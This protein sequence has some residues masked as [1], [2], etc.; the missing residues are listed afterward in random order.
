MSALAVGVVLLVA[1]GAMVWLLHRSLID[2]LDGAAQ[3]RAAEIAETLEHDPARVREL[4]RA[5]D[6]RIA[7]AQVVAP[8]GT[9]IWGFDDPHGI[10]ATP[11]AGARRAAGLSASPGYDED[12]RVASRVAETPSGRYQVLVA[13]DTESVERAVAR[14]GALLAVGAPIVVLAAAAATYLLVG[15]S[16]RSVEAIRERVARI[17]A[18]ELSE[19]VPVPAPRDEI[20]RL[21]ET[22]NDMLARVEAGHR[23][24][25]RFV[26]DA[27]HELRSPL[28]TVTAALELA[29]HRPEIV[30]AEL[31]DGTLL[32]EAERMRR[33]IDDLLTLAAAD[34]QG[35]ELRTGDVDLD[36]IAQSAAAAARLRGERTVETDIRPTRI[37]GDPER[38]ARALRNIVDNA[39]AHARSR[40]VIAVAENSEPGASA[41]RI[42]VD[43]DGPGIPAA[44]RMRVFDRFV[45]LEADRSR[46]TGGSGLGLAIVAE[47]VAAHGGAVHVA[48]SPWGGAR[49][50]VELP[51]AG[52]PDR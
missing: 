32:P 12:L 49:F 33:L 38:L 6:G 1:A 13:V 29:R 25:R 36:D 39:L 47:I 18:T 26:G 3:A 15:R 30:D 44:D 27:S 28:A 19:R 34:E 16:L 50:V 8:D 4:T 11:P 9:V 5:E 41:A 43:D 7:A 52:P 51:P 37:V 22:M 2:E 21:A 10:L 48:E 20:A 35:L 40:I 46:T 17:G 14:V 45:R 24:Q 31:I 42:V 23:A